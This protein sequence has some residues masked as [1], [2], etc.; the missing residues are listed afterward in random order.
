MRGTKLIAW[1][2]PRIVASGEILQTENAPENSMVAFM[3]KRLLE[4]VNYAL[5]AIAADVRRGLLETVGLE[6]E[7]WTEDA[8]RASIVVH[9]PESVDV[10]W[11]ARAID[12]ENLEA[13]AD[14][15]NRLHVA[16]S[17]WYS[18]KDVDQTVL[19]TIK[20]VHQFTGLLGVDL[21]ARNHAH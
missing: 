4:A 10:Q 21:A 16:V 5:A 7:W 14:R 11:I 17:P 6:S 9:L 20:V 2:A 1:R 19:C 3:Q 12:L 15:E 8:T 13:W 18:T